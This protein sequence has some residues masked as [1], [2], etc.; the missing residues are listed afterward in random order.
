MYSQSHPAIQEMWNRISGKSSEAKAD[1]ASL[2]SRRNDDEERSK[3]SRSGSIASSSSNRKSS[4]R[5]GDKSSKSSKD[6]SSRG[7]DRDRGFN[8]T[9]TSYSS[10]TQSPY[11]G[12]ASASVAT[13]SGNHNDEPYIPPGLVRNASLADQMPKS[14]SSRVERVEEERR[15]LGSERRSKRDDDDEK[16]PNWDDPGDQRQEKKEKRDKKNKERVKASSRS[17]KSGR[18]GSGYGDRESM[19]I[20]RGPAEFPGQVGAS[21]FSQ[22]PGQFN[23]GMPNTNGNSSEHPLSS[24]VQDQFPGQFPDQ[25]TA[26]YRPPIAASEG[27]PGLAAEYYGD[28]GESVAEQPGNRANTPSLIIGAEPHLQP[29]LAVAAPPPEPSASGGVGAA[30]S[31]FS[32]EFDENESAVSHGQQTAST[33][34]TAPVRPNGSHHFSAPAIPTVGGAAMGAAAGFFMGSQTSLHTQHPDHVSS[35]GGTQQ[36][37]SSSQYQ[38]PPSPTAESYYSQASRP[39]RPGKQS[40]QSSNVPLYAAGAAGAA[41][42]AAAAYQHGH[43]SSSQHGS[44]RPQN[45]MTPMA[46]RHRHQGPLGAV[47]EFFKDPDGVAQFEEYSEIIGVCKYC[48]APGSSPRDAPRKHYFRKK[49]SNDSLGRVDKDNRYHSSENEGRRK[50][51]KSWLGTD[52]AGYGLAKVGESFFKQKNDFDDTYSVKTGRYTPDG[53]NQKS[54]RRSRS[55]DG[56]ETGIASDGKVYR[57]EAQGSLFDASKTTTH[58]SRR[59]AR[60]RSRSKNGKSGINDV[61]IGASI[62]SSMAATSSRRR[63]SASP[64]GASVGSKHKKGE[65]SPERRRKSHKRKKRGFFSIG[66]ASSS[67]SSIDIAHSSDRHRN[68]KQH[69]AK[70]KDDKEAEAA[71]LGLG[72]AAAALALNEARNGHKRKGVKELV[73]VKE[74]KASDIHDSS[75]DHHSEDG[76]WES[77]PEDEYESADSAL[78]YGGPKRKGSRDSLSSDSSGTDKWRW[79][80]GSKKDRRGSPAKRKFPDHSSLSTTVGT[81]EANSAGAPTMSPDQYQGYGVNS[82]SSFPLQQVFPIPTSDPTQFDVGREASVASS[83]R[84]AL[85]PIQ[86]PQPITPVSPALY[87][88][89]PPGEHSYSAPAGPPVFSRTGDRAQP[90]NA[91]D[92]RFV[93]PDRGLPG[94]F[95]GDVL[96][97]KEAE[98]TSKPRRRDSSPARF[99]MDDVSSSMAARKR[100]STKDDISAV[101][102]DRTVE[103]EENDRRERRR[104]RREDRERHGTEERERLDKERRA[105]GEKSSEKFESSKP[106]AESPQGRSEKTWAA[107]A[108]AGIM[109][110]AVGAVVLAETSKSEETREER[111]ERRRRERE[112]EEAEDEKAV[113]RRER[114]R[115][116]R[117]SEREH[118]IAGNGS[119]KPQSFPDEVPQAQEEADRQGRISKKERSV[120]QEAASPKKGTSHEDYG[121]FFRPLELDDSTDQVKV[122]SAN[123]NADVDIDTIPAIVTVAPKGFRDPD[124][125][126]MFSSADTDDVVDTRRLSFPVPRL[127]LVEPTPPSSRGS[128][129]IIRPR[130]TVDDDVEE[131]PRDASPS[132]VTWGDDQTHEYTVISPDEDEDRGPRPNSIR[133]KDLVDSSQ[134]PGESV[135]STDQEQAKTTS[136]GTNSTNAPESFGDDVEFAATLAASAED[137]GFDPSIVIDNPTYRRRD[138]PPGSHEKSMPGGFD[139]DEE[140]TLSRGDRKKGDRSNKRRD[141]TEGSIPR[142]NNAVVQDIIDQVEDSKPQIPEEPA[143]NVV[144]DWKSGKRSKSTKSNK[145]RKKSGSK[146]DPLVSS[147][148]VVKP[149]ELASRDVYES[150][151]EDD[152]FVTSRAPRD[153]EGSSSR[154]AGKKSKTGS[155]GYDDTASTVSMSSSVVDNSGPKSK[156]KKS[157]VWDRVLG[158]FPQDNTAEDLTNEANLNES[159]KPRA[160]GEQDNSQPDSGGN[161]SQ[162]PGRITQDSPA[163][164]PPPPSIGSMLRNGILI[165]LKDRGSSTVH[166]ATSTAQHVEDDNKPEQIDEQ[167][168]ESFLDMRPEPPPPPDLQPEYEEPLD[169][170]TTADQPV[171]PQSRSEDRTRQY[172][173]VHSGDPLPSPTAVPFDFRFSRPRPSLRSARSMSQTPPSSPQ[174]VADPPLRTKPRPRSTEFKSS[175]TEFRPL[176]LVERHRSHQ[177]SA[178]EEAYPSLP[179]SHTTSRT[180]SV[181]DPEEAEHG[182]RIELEMTEE[183]HNPF[184]AE[185]GMVIHTGDDTVQSDLLD[186]Q[187]ATP[188]ASSFQHSK[189]STDVS[190][191]IASRGSLPNLDA[192][193]HSSNPTFTLEDVAL[194]AGIGGSAAFA[195]HKLNSGNDQSILLLPQE[196]EDQ[197]RQGLDSMAVGQGSNQ[198]GSEKVLPIETMVARRGIDP[199]R[200]LS[201]HTGRGLDQQPSDDMAPHAEN[202]QIYDSG[203]LAKPDLEAQVDNKLF[204]KK[205]MNSLS[206]NIDDTLADDDANPVLE[207]DLSPER[208]LYP[209]EDFASQKTK[210]G[211]KGKRKSGKSGLP[212]EHGALLDLESTASSKILAPATLSPEEVQQMQEQDVQDAVDSWFAPVSSSKKDKKKKRKGIVDQSPAFDEP[213]T[214]IDD[215]KDPKNSSRPGTQVGRQESEQLTLD[216]ASDQ[217]GDIMT[218]TALYAGNV[219]D[220]MP[221]PAP[222]PSRDSTAS[223]LE[224]RQSKPKGKKG[225]KGRISTLQ[226]DASPPASPVS[227]DVNVEDFLSEPPRQRESQATKPVG[228]FEDPA[229]FG[230]HGTPPSLELSPKERQL[231]FDE[232]LDLPKE[233]ITGHE[234]LEPRHSDSNESRTRSDDAIEA[235]PVVEEAV[236]S[237]SK[238]IAQSDRQ[239]VGTVERF[240]LATTEEPQALLKQETKDV[241]DESSA[242]ASMKPEKKGKD[243]TTS[244]SENMA[245]NEGTQ[246]NVLPGEPTDVTA[247]DQTQK[248]DETAFIETQHGSTLAE[249]DWAEFNTKKKGKRGK[250]AKQSFTDNAG[251]SAEP[252]MPEHFSTS[253]DAENSISDPASKVDFNDPQEESRTI[254]AGFSTGKRAKK[255]R[256]GKQSVMDDAETSAAVDL[257]TPSYVATPRLID[258]GPPQVS[259]EAFDDPNSQQDPGAIEDEFI[260]FRSSKKGKKAKKSKQ[261]LKIDDEDDVD[262]GTDLRSTDVA[263]Q[264]VGDVQY[265]D[266]AKQDKINSSQKE[267][268]PVEDEWAGFSSKKGKKGK[269]SPSLDAL[270]ITDVETKLP[271]VAAAHDMIGDLSAADPLSQ[272]QVIASQQ[273]NSPIEDDWARPSSKK[274]GKKDR[275]RQPKTS[276]PEREPPELEPELHQTPKAYDTG[277]DQLIASRATTST[278]QDV[279]AI[280]ESQDKLGNAEDCAETKENVNLE[281]EAIDKDQATTTVGIDRHLFKEVAVDSKAGEPENQEF[282][283]I[284]QYTG[285]QDQPK[286]KS[287]GSEF[288]ESEI[289]ELE[290]INR[291]GND[292]TM[293]IAPDSSVAATN[294]AGAVERMIEEAENT[295]NAPSHKSE[296]PAS[297]S[298]MHEAPAVILGSANLESERDVPNKKKGKKGKQFSDPSLEDAETDDSLQAPTAPKEAGVSWDQGHLDAQPEWDAPKE[299]KGTKGRMKAAAL[300]EPAMEDSL[301]ALT[302]NADTNVPLDLEPVTEVVDELYPKKSKKD[303]KNKKKTPSRASS[304]YEAAAQSALVMPGIPQGVE[305]LGKTPAAKTEVPAAEES[306][307][308]GIQGQSDLESS[309]IRQPVQAFGA[310]ETIQE[311][312]SKASNMLEPSKSIQYEEKAKKATRFDLEDGRDTVLEPSSEPKSV[313]DG[314]QDQT[315][316]FGNKSAD[317]LTGDLEDRSTSRIGQDIAKTLRAIALDSEDTTL[318]PDLSPSP[319]AYRPVAGDQTRDLRGSD[320]SVP[321]DSGRFNDGE[322]PLHEQHQS[323]GKDQVVGPA[324]E[325]SSSTAIP[326]E[327]APNVPHVIEVQSTESNVN[328]DQF[329]GDVEDPPYSFKT[330]KDKRKGKKARAHILNGDETRQQPFQVSEELNA[331]KLPDE[332]SIMPISED[333][334]D[335]SR[336]ERMMGVIEPTEVVAPVGKTFEAH[337]HEATNRR[338]MSQAAEHAMDQSIK[339]LEAESSR[340]EKLMN[341]KKSTW[342]L[343]STNEPENDLAKV[344]MATG[345]A[346]DAVSGRSGETGMG[347]HY[348][349]NLGTLEKTQITS[350]ATKNSLLTDLESGKPSSASGARD[351]LDS[352]AENEIWDIPTKK[353]KKGK[354]SN[355]KTSELEPEKDQPFTEGMTFPLLAA[356]SAQLEDVRMNKQT[357]STLSTSEENGNAFQSMETDTR[358]SSVNQ[359]PKGHIDTKAEDEPWATPTKKGKKDRK[360]GKGKSSNINSETERSVAQVPLIPGLTTMSSRQDE[361]TLEEEPQS[362]PD[363]TEGTA[364]RIDDADKVL[365]EPFSTL[366]TQEILETKDEDGLWD[367][368]IKKGKKGKKQRKGAPSNQEASETPNLNF[369]SLPKVVQASIVPISDEAFDAK[370]DAPSLA[371]TPRSVTKVELLDSQEQL[372]YDQEYAQELER[373]GVESLRNSRGVSVTSIAEPGASD[374]DFQPPYNQEHANEAMRQ[375]HEA[376]RGPSLDLANILPEA[377]N[378]APHEQ[379]EQYQEN[380]RKNEQLDQGAPQVHPTPAAEN[381]QP[382]YGLEDPRDVRQEDGETSHVPIP[383]LPAPVAEVQMLSAQEQQ[384]YD[385]E[386]AKELERQ[387]S[388]LQGERFGLPGD[389]KDT[390]SNFHP[391]IDSMTG[392]D[393]EAR[394]TLARPPP[395]EDIIEES[396]SR[397]GSIQEGSSNRSDDFSP[398]KVTNKG[399]KGKKGKKQEQP[400]IWEDD[401]ATPLVESEADRTTDVPAGSSSTLPGSWEYGASERPIDLEEP[402]RHDNAADR[403]TTSPTHIGSTRSP[404]EAEDYFAMQPGQSAEEDIGR[405]PENEDFRRSLA[406]AFPRSMEDRLWEQTTNYDT[407]GVGSAHHSPRD[408]TFIGPD[409]VDNSYQPENP[410]VSVNE[411]NDDEFS[412]APITKGKRDKKSK[413]KAVG[414][415]PRPLVKD[416]V[417]V[418]EQ[419]QRPEVLTSDLL[420]GASAT[421]RIS[422]QQSPHREEDPISRDGESMTRG[423]ISREMEAMIDT[424]GLGAAAIA[425][426]SLARPNSK[427]GS[428]KSK[429]NKKATRWADLEDETPET[430]SPAREDVIAESAEK[431]TMS[432]E[433]SNIM[434]WQENA[435]QAQTPEQQN[436]VASALDFQS[437]P[438]QSPVAPATYEPNSDTSGGRDPP[439]QTDHSKYRDSAINITES[440]VISQELPVHRALRDSGY[441]DTE[442]SPVPGSEPRHQDTRFEGDIDDSYDRSSK[443]DTQAYDNSYRT[444]ERQISAS[445]PSVS[446]ETIPDYDDSTSRR[447]ERQRR[448]RSY[449]SDDSAD[450]GFDI[451][452]RRRRQTKAGEARQP[453]PVSSTTKDRSSAL[454]DSSPS[455]REEVVGRPR[456]EYASTHNDRIRQEPTWSFGHRDSQQSETQGASRDSGL[457]Q[458]SESMPDRSTYDKLTGR[459][460][461]SSVSLFGGPH[462]Q[463]EDIMSES[464]NPPGSDLRGRRRRL[465]TISEDGQKRL[466]LHAKDKR[467]LSDVGSPEAGMKERRVQQGQHSNETESR[468]GGNTDQISSRHSDLSSLPSVP[469]KQLR[470]GEYRT[471]SAASIRSDNS[472]HAIIRTPDQVRSA[473]GQSYRSSGTPPLRRVDRS[474]SGDLRGAS[475]LGETNIRAKTSE[476]ELDPGVNTIPSSSTY[477]PVTDKGKSRANMADVYVSVCP[478]IHHHTL[479]LGANAKLQEGW[480]DVPGQ[481]PLSPTRPPSMRKRQ[482]MQLLDLETRL[483]QLVSEN[484]LLQSQKST[485]ESTLQEQTRDHSQ[486]RHAYE[487]ALEEHKMFLAQKDR[488]LDELKTIVED[489]QI[490]VTQLTEVNEELKSSREEDGERDRR[491]RELESEHLHLKD[492]HTEFTSGMESLV[493]REVSSHLE[494]KNS[495][496]QRLR[497]ELESAKQQVRNLQQQLLA[498]RESEDFVE[499]DEDYF[500][501]QCQSLCQ[502]VQQWV[503]RFSKFSD[504]KACYRAS[505]VRDENKVDRMENAI[506]DGTDVDNYLQDRVKRRDVFMAVVMTMIFD[507]IFTRYLFGMDR[508]QRQKLKNLEKT[509]Q[510]IGPMSAVCKW[511]AT[512]L[513]LLM[514]REDFAKQ[515]ATDIEAIVHEIYDTLATFLPPPSHLVA[516]IQDSL[517]KVINSAADLSVE[518]RTQ[519]ADYQMLPPLQPDYDTNGDLAQKVYFNALT[520]NER[521]GATTSNQALQEQGAVVRM[522]LFPLVVKNEEDDEQIIVC[523]AQV[524]TAD[525]KAKKT[526]RVMS[527]QGSTQG[528]RSE[529]SFAGSEGGMF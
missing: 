353:G 275:R 512:T 125:Q 34:T 153:N 456:E 306:L 518:M 190:P 38:R 261:L 185:N 252:E 134:P 460:G 323:E 366:Q 41:G 32:S 430:T 509:L 71:I 310:E 521:S 373:Q 2:T 343:L 5:G 120:R 262:L 194:T 481:A 401:T 98:M 498:S 105:F 193:E 12:T 33:F 412:Y 249:A 302:P 213:T 104:K 106:R 517:R 432:D 368:P 449:D 250:R 254:G 505:E 192:S 318:P 507:Y 68:S 27:G 92:A 334:E 445:L 305:S 336:Q 348:R 15:D 282:E 508:E 101:R 453:S 395:L 260:G 115:K 286:G 420:G 523:P 229:G 77:A 487:D 358:E 333:P 297:M 399:R 146:E 503:L 209:R 502:H 328:I 155:N 189:I 437:P 14:R 60:S 281:P 138:S 42:L 112:V 23:A 390:K 409:S 433:Q 255:S 55:D 345:P 462:Y 340:N 64:Q 337:E 139:D 352:N 394:T 22:F 451:Q 470:E 113:R 198:S 367:M 428:K 519:R 119:E 151:T 222:V 202:R 90:A 484:R 270:A 89:Q 242:I 16:A 327:Q 181:H 214:P 118:G 154:K 450:S 316:T 247:L 439:L 221:E 35:I 458:I 400:I 233:Q 259:A 495:E 335:F 365:V 210:K 257:G 100:P 425:A 109:G 18:S 380:A 416:S 363:I 447:R 203:V 141:K 226:S 389:E 372:Q 459:H 8:P 197:F 256:K 289:Q 274:Q 436:A 207:D 79:R 321:E 299:K 152:P 393:L 157:S 199:P 446:A 504:M 468:K 491:Y 431:G 136:D 218:S 72:A 319:E 396:T 290:F 284:D 375:Q 332:P 191:T 224:R 235:L 406:S 292:E 248:S 429:K 231:P 361:S 283:V 347:E 524:L 285:N 180:S 29:A 511:R 376:P 220:H 6:P 402:I 359:E 169:P 142:D 171:S 137:A 485:V 383:E 126:P 170:F 288:S 466:S 243:E 454:F 244:I 455:A 163:K 464:S 63:R 413:R 70:S 407:A 208:D 73:G 44:V 164:V 273:D 339:A 66:S 475:K 258:D 75:H 11:P 230:G 99:G 65:H 386:Y 81:A 448:S 28:A 205:A 176:M 452:R 173:Q 370:L 417:Q 300:S 87:S 49:R 147:E 313:D 496:L 69:S 1:I 457:S 58:S 83:T 236:L 435:R 177:E 422:P 423:Q 277:P 467:T 36:E 166:E 25:S 53:R 186:S 159:F 326:S 227:K 184:E 156:A 516:Q 212:E 39:P 489:W 514:R 355:K 403:S 515:R 168:P 473:S 279:T 175:N 74:T 145:G 111:R 245:T 51:D 492:R 206:E 331:L 150:P 47:V 94:T 271:M 529:A 17:T 117:E 158:R 391:S 301:Q 40:S 102:F 57:K 441:P 54:R 369:S 298:T 276:G 465:N 30:A 490:K 10:T 96:L 397:S 127:R 228:G 440:P 486:Q 379:L 526:V 174:F 382:A 217:V 499:R 329:L 133:E 183:C 268:Q 140:S 3:P 108:A 410:P 97:V 20:S 404:D 387:L 405:N 385:D 309:A 178:L 525:S 488:E 61:A 434:V 315:F 219:E 266:L 360:S 303:K 37:Y 291:Y 287:G 418:I 161:F 438:P 195:L 114:R 86:H 483:D 123:A 513:T 144:D 442:T 179:S 239:A 350:E 295:T 311:E 351:V 50:K 107:P 165:D 371:A 215:L 408:D 296:A 411:G 474:V 374:S 384:E 187:Q 443:R 377:E 330:K 26:P 341:G 238:E 471:A 56:V 308:R 200:P 362:K 304:D 477:D 19:E 314:V 320:A 59:R 78:A 121:A 272:G 130:D 478:S 354:K 95:S 196:E 427:K 211:K 480:G 398:S 148:T 122:T 80:W 293:S 76:V 424:A 82:H 160:S 463:D 414:R 149:Q 278:I 201:E 9:S 381:E 216:M 338:D 461:D 241:G 143:D 232:D 312:E 237:D 253:Q 167:R 43:Q 67:T 110:A 88:S 506:L 240:T 392:L 7:D 162:D 378:K 84:P 482:S 93:G 265:R 116:E 251:E 31:F 476:A 4:A 13:A 24:H 307:A 188:T 91:V 317:G 182:R 501:S 324:H 322:P 493:Q 128:T 131:A 426:E 52:L 21:D 225:R 356:A 479:V 264:V 48:F 349:D 103:Q 280:L 522:V 62:G 421:Q 419:S 124:A 342:E 388:P 510:E 46:Q 135:S 364:Y 494:A 204:L 263:P 223:L 85:V 325:E 234:V 444:P 267:P 472:I 520:M 269:Q 129:P 415:D 469:P 500:D 344:E 497:D 172:P 132:K 528:G 246:E 45:P 357:P 527:V 346:I 294:T